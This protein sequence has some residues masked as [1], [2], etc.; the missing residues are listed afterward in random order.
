MDFDPH[1]PKW[2]CCCCHLACGL[3]ILAAVEISIATLIAA[4]SAYSTFATALRNP[5]TLMYPTLAARA[6]FVAFVQAFGVSTVV[7]PHTTTSVEA[8]EA[9]DENGKWKSNT[10]REQHNPINEEPSVALRLVFLTF[11]MIFISIF[12]FYTIYLVV[13]CTRFINAYRRLEIRRQSLLIAGQID[14]ETTC[15]GT[16]RTSRVSRSSRN[17]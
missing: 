9:V 4:A 1:H 15:S 2:Q 11:L 14:P 17:S 10:F 5:A 8:T 6:I 13:R 16:R 3:K 7:R 12:A